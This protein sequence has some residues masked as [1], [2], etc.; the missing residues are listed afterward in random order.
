MERD[1]ANATTEV[2]RDERSMTI[3]EIVLAIAALA[4]VLLLAGLR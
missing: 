3:L 2:V 1:E 4:T